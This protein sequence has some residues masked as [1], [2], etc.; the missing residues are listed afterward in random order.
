VRKVICKVCRWAVVQADAPDCI[1]VRFGLL[2]IHILMQTYLPRITQRNK[3]VDIQITSS[4]PDKR[5]RIMKGKRAQKSVRHMET[6]MSQKSQHTSYSGRHLYHLASAL[7]RGY[8]SFL[9]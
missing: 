2:S 6:P 4:G 5:I 9:K 8:H 1:A 3:M 7:S